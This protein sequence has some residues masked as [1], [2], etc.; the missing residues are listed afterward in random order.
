MN[1]E[2]KADPIKYSIMLGVCESFDFMENFKEWGL[3]KK[4]C[5]FIG[6]DDESNMIRFKEFDDQ[7]VR[8]CN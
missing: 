3:R 4:D 2:M 1:R 6:I 5:Q 7:K 8:L